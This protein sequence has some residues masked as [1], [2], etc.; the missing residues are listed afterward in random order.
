[1]T[2]PAPDPGTRRVL[3]E[4]KTVK[5][6]SVV[7]NLNDLAEMTGDNPTEIDLPDAGL[8]ILGGLDDAL[9]AEAEDNPWV[10]SKD[11]SREIL[12]VRTIQDDEVPA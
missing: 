12:S 11:M 4:W 6:H 7:I 1:V 3:I 8:K 9:G 10:Q 5:T 2:A